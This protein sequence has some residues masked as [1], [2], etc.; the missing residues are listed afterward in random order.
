MDYK[1]YRSLYDKLDT[2]E[3]LERLQSSSDFDDEFLMVIYTQRVVR[4]ATKEFYRVKR[5]AGRLHR[6]W[7]EGLSIVELSKRYNFPPVL[8]A[9]IVLEKE[10]I[11]RRQFWKTVTNL[12]EIED[13]RLQR[14]LREA[15]EQ[16]LVYSPE[17]TRRQYERGEW[18]EERLRTWLQGA[19]ISFRVEEDLRAEFEKTPDALLEEPLK[20]DGSEISWIESK[21]TFGDPVEVK[22]HARRQLAP[23][24]DLFGDGLVIY[25]FGYAEDVELKLPDGVHISDGRILEQ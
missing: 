5:H 13:E 14:E 24:V 4:E 19:G 17:G 6:H 9:L 15:C 1:T 8:M 21:A 23:Y 25:W 7:K 10:G 20:F 16:D 3:A 2:K 12:D 22:R 18:G 11:S